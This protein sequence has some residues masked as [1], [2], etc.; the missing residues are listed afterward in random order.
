ML[1]VLCVYCVRVVCVV[2]RACCVVR[3][4]CVLCCVLYCVVCAT[5]YFV[6]E[7][8]YNPTYPTLLITLHTIHFIVVKD[9]R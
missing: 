2:L 3:V 6:S 9:R 1:R 7:V 8:G 4:V 5:S